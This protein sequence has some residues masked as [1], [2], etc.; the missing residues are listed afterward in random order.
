MKYV[1]IA[2]KFISGIL[3]PPRCLACD[4]T[5]GAGIICEPCFEKIPRFKTLFCAECSARMPG[6]RKTCH[7]DTPYILGPACPYDDPTA[8]LL[9]RQL[10]FHDVRQAA[11]PLA[12]LLARYLAD[13]AIN[14]SEFILIPMPLS[15]RRRNERGF[16]QAEEIARRL[17]ERLPLN[18]RNDILA[19]SRHAKPQTET[20]NAAE[21]QRN[22]LGCFSVV[23]PDAVFR[24]DIIIL[25]DVTTS[26]ATLGEAARTLKAAGARTII[27]LAAAKA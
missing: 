13:I 20:T 22:I 10:K 2:L 14:T 21:R 7:R 15:R 8:K 1:T 19:R 24:K 25:D 27:G 17:A 11:E 5:L 23:R 3:F 18:I 16:N 4:A 6:M 12:G 26:G 9:I